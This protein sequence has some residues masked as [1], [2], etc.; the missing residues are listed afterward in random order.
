MGSKL[1]F[2]FCDQNKGSKILELYFGKRIFI[3]SILQ[4]FMGVLNSITGE[5]LKNKLT[6]K[7]HKRNNDRT[8]NF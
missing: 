6:P 3:S 2:S 7:H 5:K 8:P 4:I 1:P